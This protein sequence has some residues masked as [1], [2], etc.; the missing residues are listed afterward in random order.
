MRLDQKKR[1]V[2]NMGM[3]TGSAF[4]SATNDSS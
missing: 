2:K 3:W 1:F 4:H